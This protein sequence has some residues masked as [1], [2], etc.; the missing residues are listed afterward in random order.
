MLRRKSRFGKPK[1]QLKTRNLTIGS[2]Q[3]RTMAAMLMLPSGLPSRKRLFASVSRLLKSVSE[4]QPKL[5][6][7]NSQLLNT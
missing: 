5:R 7:A 6:Q 3:S 2:R 1:R 4:K